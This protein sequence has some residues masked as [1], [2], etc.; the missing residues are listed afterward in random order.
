MSSKYLSPSSIDPL[1]FA[2]TAYPILCTVHFHSSNI[3][4]WYNS[5]HS[6]WS[7]IYGYYGFES[8]NRLMR[9][10]FNAGSPRLLGCIG[11]GP[12]C[13]DHYTR[14]RAMRL[15]Y[16]ARILGCNSVEH[17]ICNIDSYT[18]A[19]PIFQGLCPLLFLSDKVRRSVDLEDNLSRSLHWRPFIIDLLLPTQ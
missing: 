2:P 10:T 1:L 8:I 3:I 13:G 18:S 16:M 11:I 9:Y 5:H 4:T 14:C 7:E 6:F 19:K 12:K 17:A 15:G